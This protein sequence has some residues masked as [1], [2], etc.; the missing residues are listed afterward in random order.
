MPKPFIC[1]SALYM[2]AS[3][4]RMLSKALT[5]DADAIIV[6]LEDSVAPSMKAQAR[7]M[8][9]HALSSFDYGHRIRVL[10]INGVG[11]QWHDADVR[12]IGIAK[13]DAVLL[14]KVE[15]AETLRT[16]SMQ[17]ESMQLTETSLWAMMETPAAVLAAAQIGA[18]A[19]QDA[20]FQLLC[21]GTNDLAAEAGMD[22]SAD[23]TFLMP[24][25]MQ[26]VAAARANGLAILDGVHNDFRDEIMFERL[27]LQGV[28]MGMTGKTLIHPKQIACANEVW[29]P[30]DETVR[31]SQQ[32]V[33]T[34]AK[35]ENADA[36]V[37]QIEGRMI[38]RLHL[39]VAQATLSMVEELQRRKQAGSVEPRV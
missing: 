14:P 32:I 18:Y 8:A 11:T 4:E 27:C 31:K 12:C 20:R 29:T 21:L 6:D 7:E 36:G 33:D 25:L 19:L 2:P 39:A 17:L 37:L 10:R 16:L 3:S 38:E 28:A 26:F 23:G 5:L 22:V 30:N 13:P 24:W 1:R 15:S 9:V 35:A 34:F